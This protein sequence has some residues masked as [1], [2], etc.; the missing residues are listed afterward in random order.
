MSRVLFEARNIFLPE[1]DEAFQM[2]AITNRRCEGD[3]HGSLKQRLHSS[4]SFV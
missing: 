3:T 1:R 2:S 4:S